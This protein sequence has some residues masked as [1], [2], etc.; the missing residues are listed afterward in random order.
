MI[1]I[2]N[3]NMVFFTATDIEKISQVLDCKPQ[4]FEGGWSW[5]L[6]NNELKQSLLFTVYNKVKTINEESELI[7]SV[8]TQHG[9]YELHQCSGY[10]IFEPDEVIF[11]N[12]NNDRVSSLIIGKGC[13]CSMYSNINRQI[14]NTDISSLEAAL[15]P[16]AMQLS[17]LEN[18][19]P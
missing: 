2:Q 17:L 13:A 19:L 7:I 5:H 16:S 10:M 15:L 12:I 11:Y 1:L 3:K 6:N 14:M 4:L 8:Q 9:F 18:I